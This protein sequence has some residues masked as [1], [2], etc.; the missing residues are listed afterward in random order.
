M[1]RST[2][3]IHRPCPRERGIRSD[4]PA[5]MML[6]WAALV[7]ALASPPPARAGMP[8]PGPG[9]PQPSD[10]PTVLTPP[11]L[12]PGGRVALCALRDEALDRADS[13]FTKLGLQNLFKNFYCD[14]GCFMCCKVSGNLGCHTSFDYD[15]EGNAPINCNSGVYGPGTTIVGEALVTGDPTGTGIC[16]A[17]QQL[18]NH[19]PVCSADPDAPAAGASNTGPSAPAATDSAEA[20]GAVGAGAGATPEAAD[21]GGFAEA[22]ST[23]SAADAA[24]SP[25]PHPDMTLPGAIG[26]R[27][28]AFAK[29]ILH[30]FTENVKNRAPG[31]N[32]RD[33]VDFATARG[34]RDWR[35]A[36]AEIEPYGGTYSVFRVEDANGALLPDESYQLGILYHANL[37]LLGSVPNV[38]TRLAYVESRYWTEQEKADYLGGV[39]PEAELRKTMGPVAL[40]SLKQVPIQDWR[41]LSVPAPNE[42]PIVGR[43]FE[44]F[45]L[46]QAPSVSVALD[47][48]DPGE[49]RLALDLEDPE[50]AHRPDALYPVIVAWGDGSHTEFVYDDALAHNVV[51]HVYAEPGSYVAYVTASNVTGLRGVAGIVIERAGGNA[52]PITP[53]IAT[54]SLDPVAAYGPALIRAGSLAF[55]LELRRPDGSIVEAGYSEKVTLAN[56]GSTPLRGMTAYNEAE[57]P[58][59]AVVLRPTSSGGY[60]YDSVYFKAPSLTVGF[61]D[62]ELGEIVTRTLPVTD[63][64]L[65]VYYEG[66]TAPV[67]PALLER[68][69]NGALI[70]PV[71][72]GNAALA[73]GF[74]GPTACKRVD[75]IEIPISP[76]L[77]AARPASSPV[78]PAG[79]LAGDVARWL[80]D[81][82]NGFIS[83]PD[84]NAT[85]VQGSCGQPPRRLRRR[86]R[87]EP[88]AGRRAFDRGRRSDRR[89]DHRCEPAGE[90]DPRRR[91]GR[92]RHRSRY[93]ELRRPD[94]AHGLE[95]S[96]QG[97]RPRLDAS[98]H[99]ADHGD[100]RRPRRDDQR[101][102]REPRSRLP[103][104]SLPDQRDP[105]KRRTRRSECRRGDGRR[106]GAGEQDDE[107]RERHDRGIPGRHLERARRQR[108]HRLRRLLRHRL[109]EPE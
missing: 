68:D 30:H 50:L 62:P 80:E 98:R 86:G 27:A 44:G 59:D 104:L 64:M 40:E 24:G 11:D 18:C 1:R 15:D 35:T 95:R 108:G 107:C 58:V 63:D 17:V 93:L 39:D 32:P 21:L 109:D 46:G 100:P 8:F 25:P 97:P 47:C 38:L 13:L 26:S 106:R 70:I 7:F 20:I 66:S 79:L 81:V 87:P 23:A 5:L 103:D 72:R 6:V 43:T 77:L 49:T 55:E 91:P 22:S 3:R 12:P 90:R 74:C 53:S 28:K 9:V 42:P 37:A 29:A 67:P 31:S 78:L 14:G 84:T 52:V 10:P 102:Q 99:C 4:R 33:Y 36:M 34:A 96:R 69:I 105:R 75:R 73:A 45:E 41:L 57:T 61:F 16:L 83:D 54:L 82:P 94:R 56:A 88:V 65:E 51:S 85:V 92:R 48:S 101:R 2:S 60:F 76:T 89:R 71:D 19:L